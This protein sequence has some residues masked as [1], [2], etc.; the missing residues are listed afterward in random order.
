MNIEV[1]EIEKEDT[2]TFSKVK[3]GQYFCIER[4]SKSCYVKLDAEIALCVS[5]NNQS[6]KKGII[7]N[8]SNI[9][10]GTLEVQDC[11]IT[12]QLL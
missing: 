9:I 8:F 7:Y 2:E 10:D 3:S 12:I 5:S 1:I 6:F 11:K 4:I